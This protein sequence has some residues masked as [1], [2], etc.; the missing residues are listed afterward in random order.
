MLTSEKEKD[1]L[2]D[3]KARRAAYGRSR[4]KVLELK[5]AGQNDLAVELMFTE[6]NALQTVYI[7]AWK[8]FIEPERDLLATGVA[9]AE[10]TH[11]RATTAVWSVLALALVVGFAVA[12]VRTRWL[13]RSLSGEPAYASAITMRIAAGDLT[14]GIV[15]KAGDRHSLLFAMDS[16]RGNLTHVIGQMQHGA[17][18][19]STATSEIAAGNLD[20]SSRTGQQASA[21]QQTASSMERLTSTVAQ[22]VSNARQADQLASSASLVTERGGQVVAQVVGTMGE[23]ND[24]ARKIVDI[25]GVID[26]IAFQNNI[27]ALN[28]AVEAARAGEQGRGFAVGIRPHSSTASSVAS[29]SSLNRWPSPDLT[30]VTFWRGRRHNRALTSTAPA[31]GQAQ[32]WTNESLFIN[33]GRI[34]PVRNPRTGGTELAALQ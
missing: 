28:A 21:L 22:N 16:M 31:P 15:L 26:G 29:S 18:G 5:K 27:L 13:L 1:L 12:T 3:V 24:S 32:F 17:D 23:I 14:T 20:L 10:D 33:T 34:A 25:I 19:V 30:S 8:T 11:S 9:T 4:N 2:A 7:D 6:T